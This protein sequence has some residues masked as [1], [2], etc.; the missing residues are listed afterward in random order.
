MSYHLGVDLGSTFSAVAACRAD[1]IAVPEIM[2]TVVFVNPDG[3]VVV[4][5]E[6]DRR[7]L[8]DPERVVRQFTRRIG[9]GVPILVGGVS[10][11]A[12]VLAAR[13]VTAMLDGPTGRVT[14]THPA[15][16]GTH[17]VA[18]L[19]DALAGQGLFG[20]RFLP[21]PV[22]AVLA[23]GTRERI[24]HGAAVAVYDL[25]GTSFE[26]TV[27]RESAVVDPPEDLE[28]GGLD[29]D[30]VVFAHVT[31]A[32]GA[33]WGELDPTDP[34]VRAAV[35][36]L[37]RGC[38]AAKEALSADTEVLIPVALPGIDTRIRLA[39]AEFE[40]AIRPAIEETVAALERV[41]GAAGA[42][43]GA[44]L[45]VGG[46]ARIPLIT[47][48]VSERLGR[49]VSTSFD[50]KGIVAIG[51]AIEARGPIPAPTRVLVQQLAP[52]PAGGQAYQPPG[53]IPPL[54]IGP[55]R[56]DNSGRWLGLP[57]IIVAAV[58]ATVLAGGVAGG[59]TVLASRTEPATS[60]AD[61]NAVSPPTT[62]ATVADPVVPDQTPVRNRP[63]AT[64]TAPPR[65]RKP[66]STAATTP[67]PTTDSTMKPPPPSTSVT[68]TSSPTSA[69]T[70]PSS[71]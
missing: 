54:P 46:S 63:P 17:R 1:G 3:S 62:T 37:R 21:A 23:H 16:W 57:R 35:A 13:F 40:D 4:G 7:G 31:T 45:L 30:E 68:T 14:I 36:G 25:G 49:P 65:P 41:L 33:A 44:V 59:L 50:P 22:A 11:P 26:A 8:A 55:P 66:E 38:T 52:V 43:P 70:R 9:D 56:A 42:E 64:T 18:A 69:S 29:L 61:T 32:L 47:Q 60:D 51:A 27:V 2:P 20:T 53:V 19:R 28:L 12:E 71:R 15:G 6:A 24:E 58:A 48:T 34:A 67:R 5:D 39:R 10:M